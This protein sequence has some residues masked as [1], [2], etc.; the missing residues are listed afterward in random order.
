MAASSG[1]NT[2]LSRCDS[3]GGASHAD[4]R[5]AI[6]DTKAVFRAEL[7]ALKADWVAKESNKYSALRAEMKRDLE[8]MEA[9]LSNFAA[10]SGDSGRSAPATSP[11]DAASMSSSFQSWD[12]KAFEKHRQSVT[13][14][15]QSE[16]L[17]RQAH[18]K[19]LEQRLSFQEEWIEEAIHKAVEALRV[20]DENA[21]LV[22]LSH[23]LAVLEARVRPAEL[24]GRARAGSGPQSTQEVSDIRTYVDSLYLRMNDLIKVERAARQQMVDALEVK[25]REANDRIR[26]QGQWIE[27]KFEQYTGDLAG[28]QGELL[29]ELQ[30][31][32]SEKAPLEGRVQTLERQFENYLSVQLTKAA[33][34]GATT[35]RCAERAQSYLQAQSPNAS[36]RPGSAHD[37]SGQP[38][39]ERGALDAKET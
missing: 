6:A 31:S 1:M 14:V 15:L 39:E 20:S 16:K 35:P 38:D 4:L 9:T 28:L 34:S 19:K 26:S 3:V 33:Q 5:A 32:R 21:E 36:G 29:L 24:E 30:G 18:E 13:N 37:V 27:E 23:R 11:D 7:K 8:S 2:P 17:Q 25:L 22:D 12:H 10:A